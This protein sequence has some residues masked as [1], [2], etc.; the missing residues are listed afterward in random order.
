M[1]KLNLLLLAVSYS[2]WLLYML[3]LWKMLVTVRPREKKKKASLPTQFTL[4]RAQRLS[5]IGFLIGT[6]SSQPLK[7]SPQVLSDVFVMWNWLSCNHRSN[8]CTATVGINTRHVKTLCCAASGHFRFLLV[9]AKK[10][11]HPNFLKSLEESHKRKPFLLLSSVS[12]TVALLQFKFSKIGQ[13]MISWKIYDKTQSHYLK[14]WHSR[15]L[16]VFTLW[17]FYLLFL[18]PAK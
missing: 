15:I 16:L 2:T 5:K 9:K 8:I 18:W 1:A 14:V 6:A 3:V 4:P 7:W 17:T 13:T 10:A 11:V 12:T